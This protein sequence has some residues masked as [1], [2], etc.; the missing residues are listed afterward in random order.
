MED[1]NPQNQ[2]NG[3]SIIIENIEFT[4]IYKVTTYE[5]G[6]YEEIYKSPPAKDETSRIVKIKSVNLSK[7]TEEFF[8]VYLS[9]SELGV[10]RFLCYENLETTRYD[11][12]KEYI[13]STCVNMYLQQHLHLWYDRLEEIT[14]PHDDIINI[15]RSQPGFI[16]ITHENIKLTQEYINKNL[17]ILHDSNREKFFIPSGN[18]P[19]KCG[20][21][22]N[23]PEQS[24]IRQ[25]QSV[26]QYLQN[27]YTILD[28][29]EMFHYNFIFRDVINSEN[30][31]VKVTL[32]HKNTNQTIILFYKKMVFSKLESKTPVPGVSRKKQEEFDMNIDSITNPG[33]VHFVVILV[34]PSEARCLDN[35]LYSEYI[36]L[37]IY[38]CK[39]FDYTRLLNSK[40]TECTK[41]YSY[42]GYRYQNIF[43]IKNVE[44]Q[45]LSKEKK[46]V[47]GG[48]MSKRKKVNNNIKRKSRKYKNKIT[49]RKYRKNKKSIKI[50]RYN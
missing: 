47:L 12:G 25:I 20:F 26:S 8:W 46:N 48:K 19:I 35:S 49:N 21:T 31:V 11:K 45:L 22:V 41:D 24:V 18:L 5:T 9:F 30:I 13:Q 14:I 3:L 6:I 17:P 2:D 7:Q 43:P 27:S 4:L 34:I 32:K 33:N 40:L 28:Y 50:K 16:S 39:P 44:N 38:V 36:N 29:E 42:V 37:G 23:Y 1:I 10:W 15:S